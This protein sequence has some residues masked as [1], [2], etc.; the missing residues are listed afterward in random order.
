MER[1]LLPRILS[2]TFFNPTHPAIEKVKQIAS[3]ATAEAVIGYTL[4]MRD[5]PDQ[6]KTL[7]SV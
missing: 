3:Q 1:T 6:I 2:S 5:R 4:A 7:E